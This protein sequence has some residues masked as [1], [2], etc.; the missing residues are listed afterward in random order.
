[1]GFTEAVEALEKSEELGSGQ[2]GAHNKLFLA[3]TYARLGD[4]AESRRWYDKAVT[5]IDKQGIDEEVQRSLTEA[6]QLL[7]SLGI[8]RPE[9]A[10]SSDS[11]DGVQPTSDER[12]RAEERNAQPEPM[13][14]PTADA[15]EVDPS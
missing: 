9:A 6:V 5:W 13:T 1:M 15:V 4:E 7:E 2:S 8:L 12:D 10:V 14:E 11:S 3:M